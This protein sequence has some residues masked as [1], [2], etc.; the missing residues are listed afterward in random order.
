V[1][2]DDVTKAAAL[3]EVTA[4]W[5]RVHDHM[6]RALLERFSLEECAAMLREPLRQAGAEAA[7]A[8]ERPLAPAEIGARIMR[9]ERHWE[10]EGRVREHGPRRFEREVAYCPWAHFAP[11]SCRLLGWY[12]EGYVEALSPACRYE[13][14]ELMPEGAPVCAWRITAQAAP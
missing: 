8:G 2:E 14:T 1:G 5:G 4:A 11:A 10:I 12:M 3:R 13:L 7:E 6:T 9:F